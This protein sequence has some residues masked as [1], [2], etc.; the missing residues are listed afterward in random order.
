MQRDRVVRVQEPLDDLLDVGSVSFDA[1]EVAHRLDDLLAGE[2]RRV[3]GQTFRPSDH[4][5]DR[6][7]GDGRIRGVGPAQS[8]EAG[9]ELVGPEAERL[10]LRAPPRDKVVRVDAVLLGPA[11]RE[12]GGL[13][14]AGGG[15]A[16][17][18]D[19][20]LD[21]VPALRERA[22][23]LPRDAFDLCPT[24]AHVPPSDAEP[25]GEEVAEL[26]L[27]QH[28]R[29]TGVVEQRTTIDRLPPALDGLGQIRG[30]HV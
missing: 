23:D 1:D 26:D 6:V 21:L 15:V 11:G 20:R 27:V 17:L 12:R 2:G 8:A 4:A 22:H 24:V 29:R 25:L 19:H 10:G 30:D 3:L 18:G 9:G 16:G 7:G 5:V 28:P 13:V 14:G